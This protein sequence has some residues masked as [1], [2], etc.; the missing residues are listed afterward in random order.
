MFFEAEY[1]FLSVFLNCN[2]QH[3]S[4]ADSIVRDLEKQNIEG[5]KIVE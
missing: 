1:N 5:W 3:M 4:L 2:C